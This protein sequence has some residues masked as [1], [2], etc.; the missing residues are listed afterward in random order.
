MCTVRATSSHMT[1][2]LTAA[3]AS[4][5]MVKGPWFCMSTA[6]LRESRSVWLRVAGRLLPVLIGAAVVLTG[7]H[8]FLDVVAGDAIVLAALAVAAWWLSRDPSA[9]HRRDL[10]RLVD[11][12]PDAGH[13]LRAA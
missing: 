5:P 3:R 8:Y 9:Q 4:R 11:P 7:N 10:A 2:A 13:D 1:A 12:Q 6:G